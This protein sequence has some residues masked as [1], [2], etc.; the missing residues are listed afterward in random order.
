M[1]FTTTEGG[2][3]GVWFSEKE[4][5]ELEGKEEPLYVPALLSVSTMKFSF[6]SMCCMVMSNSLIACCHLIFISLF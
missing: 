4:K 6:P 1:W 3:I 5:S 2:S